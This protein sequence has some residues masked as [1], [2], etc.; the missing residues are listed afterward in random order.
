MKVYTS[1]CARTADEAA[2]IFGLPEKGT[3][4]IMLAHD[5][6]LLHSHWL[7]GRCRREFYPAERRDALHM[8]EAWAICLSKGRE[9][10]NY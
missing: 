6:P 7:D 4:Q 1:I 2:M 5:M 3:T 9:P 10:V 8:G